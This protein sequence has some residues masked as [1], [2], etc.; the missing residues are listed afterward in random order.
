[1]ENNTQAIVT[2]IASF[3]TSSNLEDTISNVLDEVFK[4]NPSASKI[5]VSVSATDDGGSYSHS[6]LFVYDSY[7]NALDK[8][9]SLEYSHNTAVEVIEAN[10]KG[11]SAIMYKSFDGT[12]Y[13]RLANVHFNYWDR[14]KLSRQ[15]WDVKA[16][17]YT[18][19]YEMYKED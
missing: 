17:I 4:T 8:I 13:S 18:V 2:K 11:Y 3:T 10:V 19:N 5:V 6:D 1:M 15:L 9:N 7:T 12:G 14:F 16:D